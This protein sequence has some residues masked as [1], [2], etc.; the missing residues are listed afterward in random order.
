MA[1]DSSFG[2]E[3]RPPLIPVG[4]GEV[5]VGEDFRRAYAP[6]LC[7]LRYVAFKVGIFRTSPN[8]GGDFLG[9]EKLEEIK[10]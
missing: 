4:W 8:F 10:Q 9:G 1:G 5:D 3:A 7:G 6:P 2:S